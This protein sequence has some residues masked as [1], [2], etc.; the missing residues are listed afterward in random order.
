MKIYFCFFLTYLFAFQSSC[1]SREVIVSEQKLRDLL[2]HY[3]YSPKLNKAVYVIVYP[4]G[5]NSC[6]KSVASW[7]VDNINR[8]VTAI[9]SSSSRKAINTL[10]DKSVR[11][12]PNFLADST[13]LCLGFSLQKFPQFY[14]CKDGKLIEQL[15]YRYSNGE[16]VLS[17]VEKHLQNF[18]SEF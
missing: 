3:S 7:I 12:H 17:Q 14:L 18:S 6:T 8:P 5:C 16:D 4:E 9:I 11:C 13:E 2:L 1:R 15:E 10:F